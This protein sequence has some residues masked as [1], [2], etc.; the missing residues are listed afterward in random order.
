ME[1]QTKM[2]K[3]ML[4]LRLR[5][6]GLDTQLHLLVS[7]PGVPRCGEH[8]SLS[9]PLGA[10]PGAVEITSVRWDPCP[11]EIGAA[12]FCEALVEVPAGAVDAYLPRLKAEG[13]MLVMRDREA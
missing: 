11:S 9:A 1:G 12:V 7:L 5:E 3:I 2:E 6:R 10:I 8:I 4:G 13:W